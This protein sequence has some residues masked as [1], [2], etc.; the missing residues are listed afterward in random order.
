MLD[1]IRRNVR[2]PYIQVLLGLIILVFVLFFGWG[3]ESQKPN[4]VAKV[5]SDTIEYRPYQEAYSG[6]VRLY[7]EAFQ[8]DLSGDR[9]RELQLGRRALD[10]LV[11]RTLLMQEASRRRLRVTEAELQAAIEAVSVFQDAGAFRKDLYL[12][13][14]DANRLSPLEYET[15]KRNEMLLQKVEAAIRAEAAV[16]DADVEQEFLDR[17]TRIALEYASVSPE[18]LAA[19][20]KPTAAQLEEFYHAEAESFRVPE[21]RSARYVLFRPEDYLAAVAV[22][23]QEAED[24]YRWR[25]PEFAVTEAVR[26]RHLLLRVD[27]TAD[28]EEEGRVRSQAEELRRAVLDGADFADL[29]RKSSEDPGSKDQGGDLGYFERGQMVP[30]F[31]AAAFSA[32]SGTVSEPVRTA[33]G[34]HLILVEDRREARQPPFDEVAEALT[35]EIRRRKALEE[36]YAAADNLLMD[37]EDGKSTWEEVGASHSV[38]TTEPLTRGDAPGDVERPAEFSAALFDL[39]PDRPGVLL[40][41]R[42]GTYL[43]AVEAVQPSAVPP[44]DAVRDRVAARFRTAEG[45][46]LAEAR[47]RDFLAAASAKGWD[48][49]LQ[50]FGLTAHRTAP[51]PKKGG[52]VPGLGWAPSLK[53]AAFA[54]PEVG[55][56]AA[57]PSEVN[58]TFY[59]FRVAERIDA[60]PASLD[61]DRERLQAELLPAKQEDYLQRYLEALRANAKIVVNE[62]LLF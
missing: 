17:N 55:G 31:E 57:E 33:F 4:Y 38:Q 12:R 21:R 29:A 37:L 3:I 54:I 2:H 46:R 53:E 49:A 20:V 24:E 42:G 8:G 18:N 48:E 16:T 10:Q 28:S 7:Q 14:L 1:K 43:L 60:D 41:S 59:A 15:S 36:A 27:P 56:V 35:A 45:L 52:A 22:S 61:A 39:L 23:E 58:G 25:S 40:E 62:A 51:F 34:Y 6:L 50:S 26:A 47:A 30:E 9:L 5:N 13:V 32:E 19:E 44:L 11:D